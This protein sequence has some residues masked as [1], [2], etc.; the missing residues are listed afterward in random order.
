MEMKS[1]LSWNLL[2]AASN[3]ALDKQMPPTPVGDDSQREG[4]ARPEAAFGYGD[5][6]TCLLWSVPQ[7]EDCGDFSSVCGS[8]VAAGQG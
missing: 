3:K 8:Q 2:S 5:R 7:R 1:L 6:E 4:W